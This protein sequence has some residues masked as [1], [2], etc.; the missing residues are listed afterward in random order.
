MKSERI[1]ASRSSRCPCGAYLGHT[2]SMPRG[3]STTRQ[4]RRSSTRPSGT[5]LSHSETDF[6]ISPRLSASVARVRSSRSD[7]AS[8]LACGGRPSH[9]VKRCSISWRSGCCRR[10]PGGLPRRSC[11]STV[12]MWWQ[13]RSATEAVAR[14]RKR[15]WA[16]KGAAGCGR[17]ES[18]DAWCWGSPSARADV[19]ASSRCSCSGRDALWS[20]PTG[21]CPA[22]RRGPQYFTSTPISTTSKWP[23]LRQIG[24]PSDDVDRLSHDQLL[25]A[26]VAER[27]SEA[28]SHALTRESPDD[29]IHRP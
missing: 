2:P 24:R 22:K 25:S 14:S 12:K 4:R 16:P 17:P 21:R 20:G 26:A 11:G 23:E 13:R 27:A 5:G 8:A 10:G 6:E 7:R 29:C 18:G 1:R 19:A 3:S 9:R 28:R 15:L